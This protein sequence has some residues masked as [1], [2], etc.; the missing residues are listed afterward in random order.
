DGG[1][2]RLLQAPADLRQFDKHHVAKLRLRV[3]ANAN[4]RD[5]AFDVEPF[6][7]G[8]EQRGHD[9]AS[10]VYGVSVCRF[11]VCKFNVCKCWER[12]AS[13]G[14]ARVL[15]QKRSR[16][17]LRARRA[18]NPSPPARSGWGRIRPR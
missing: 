8:G 10:S 12:T 5:V 16:Y 17:W 14:A 15:R 1:G 13:A 11:N 6:V 2:F 7:I 4:G 9:S 18:D 3:I